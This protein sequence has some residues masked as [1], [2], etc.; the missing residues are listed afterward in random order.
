[1]RI[2]LVSSG[3]VARQFAKELSADY[4]VTVVHS[5]EEGRSEL[6][7]YDCQLIDG[8]G[9]D[10][11]VM[12][13]AGAHRADWVIACSR[14]DELNLLT[15]LTTRQLGK[16]K[17]ICFVGKEEYVRTFGAFYGG[18]VQ[19]APQFGIDRII[20]PARMLATRIERILAV[21]GATDV[22]RF[23]RGQLSFLE[24]KLSAKLPL[25]GR[26]LMEIRSLP[27]QVLLVGVRRG[28]DWFVPRGQ[29]VL[30]EGDRVHFIGKSASMHQLSAWFT[31]HLGSDKSSQIVIVG[32]GTVGLRLAR[33]LE[34]N[35]SLQV[36]LIENDMDRCAEIAQALE[37]ALVLNGDGCDLDLLETE[38]V[39]RARALV[40]VTDSDEKNLLA[41][42]LGSQLGIPKIV[43]RVSS[44]A[45]LR[46]FERVGIDVPLSA[47]AAATEAVLHHIRHEEVDLLATLGEGQGEVVELIL[48]N[49]FTP[50][51]LKEL[52]LPQ[53]SIIAAIERKGEA[54][55]PGGA[56]LLGP[57]DRCYVVCSP[58]RV[59]EVR[60]AMNG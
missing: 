8:E 11:D 16:A 22:G 18:R 3:Q 59:A 13:R 6:E 42:L 45:N 30:E 60:E 37:R 57:G 35:A 20:W 43:T 40:A 31:E 34:S 28:D 5:G 21:P 36:K 26:P 4:D 1:M 41:S 29:S 12:K 58:E 50:R 19:G 27:S 25:V 32:G 48:D 53:D 9:N 17:T 14:S 47:R 33:S 49:D 54:L 7:R 10:I 52:I 51:P 38:Q 39:W 55:V 2:V 15:C 24:Y 56:T 46:V 44:A 23:A